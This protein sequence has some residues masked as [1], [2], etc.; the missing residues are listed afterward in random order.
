MPELENFNGSCVNVELLPVT[1]FRDTHLYFY[2]YDYALDV[3]ENKSGQNRD[4]AVAA[5]TQSDNGR[6]RPQQS[7]EGRER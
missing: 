3:S 2:T 1:C 4:L 5:T 6:S 7:R